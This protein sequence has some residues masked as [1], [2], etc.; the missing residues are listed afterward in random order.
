M[1]SIISL[2]AEGD[3]TNADDAQKGTG[4]SIHSLCAEG[5]VKLDQYFAAPAISIH[6]LYT[7]GDYRWSDDLMK[8]AISIHSLYAEGDHPS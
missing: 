7:E 1:S 3:L 4:I 2:Y 5:D 8:S 6:S